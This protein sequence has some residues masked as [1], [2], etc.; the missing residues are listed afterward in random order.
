MSAERNGTEQ[1][2]QRDNNEHDD[3]VLDAIP[4]LSDAKK[5]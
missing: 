2:K 1:K 3:W 5:R 4:T